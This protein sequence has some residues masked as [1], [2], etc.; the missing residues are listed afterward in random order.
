MLQCLNQRLAY[1]TEVRLQWVQ[2]LNWKPALSGWAEFNGRVKGPWA[3]NCLW[4]KA[5]RTLQTWLWAT[6]LARWNLGQVLRKCEILSFW[7]PP[8]PHWV[9]KGECFVELILHCA[10]K[11]CHRMSLSHSFY[12]V[13]HKEIWAV[14]DDIATA[15]T[16]N[17]VGLRL[18]EWTQYCED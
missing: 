13:S 5:A 14:C 2:A 7:L 6:V 11:C 1:R 3:A 17:V 9:Q 15:S 8:W 12:P 10:E 4:R 16:G 18:H